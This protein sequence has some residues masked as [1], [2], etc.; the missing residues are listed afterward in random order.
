MYTFTFTAAV[1]T[2][3]SAVYGVSGLTTVSNVQHTFYGDPDNDGGGNAIAFNCGRGYTAK[4]R[5]SYNDPLTFASVRGKYNKCEIVWDPY[6]RKYLRNEDIC[7]TCS[8]TQIDIWTGAGGSK[9]A[10][11][12]CE[13][14]LTPDR[15]HNV[16]RFGSKDHQSNTGPLWDGSCHPENVY[17]DAK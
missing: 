15:G 8:G 1:V 4:G 6:T 9:K 3:L 17:P 11:L 12:A 2:I 10:Q 16:I 14:R 7:A 5:G 13:R